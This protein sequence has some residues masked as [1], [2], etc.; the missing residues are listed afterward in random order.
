MLNFSVLKRWAKMPSKL[1]TQ[2]EN[3]IYDLL[4]DQLRD[5]GDM[6]TMLLSGY[7]KPKRLDGNEAFE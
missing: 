2:T 5:L 3:L 4:I 1:P 6:A 7:I